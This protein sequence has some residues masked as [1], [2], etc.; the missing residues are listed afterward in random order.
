MDVSVASIVVFSV[1]EI[2]SYMGAYR[3]EAFNREVLDSQNTMLVL[4][5]QAH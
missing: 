1:S 3:V 5:R 4:G 2:A